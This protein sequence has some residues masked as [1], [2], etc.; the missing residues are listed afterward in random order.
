MIMLKGIIKDLMWIVYHIS[1][2]WKLIHDNFI[3]SRPYTYTPRVPK[4]T[5]SAVILSNSSYTSKEKDDK[6]DCSD[7]HRSSRRSLDEDKIAELAR[8]SL[9]YSP[10]CAACEKIPSLV[11]AYI[12]LLLKTLL[13]ILIFSALASIAWTLFW[14]VSKKLNTEAKL[15]NMTAST[16]ESKYYINNCEAVLI[17]PEL[18]TPWNELYKCMNSN[19]ESSTLYSKI[20]AGLVAE[21]LNDFFE[22]ISY[23]TIAKF[24]LI[25][26]ILMVLEIPY[27]QYKRLKMRKAKWK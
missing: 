21:I 12:S 3:E 5:E 11:E 25:L 20:A 19:S 8:M 6:E 22:T 26:A 17:P 15:S 7:G 4:Q 13:Q 24:L 18:E 1:F 27:A 16:C 23:D 9:Y 2:T 14:D 10:P